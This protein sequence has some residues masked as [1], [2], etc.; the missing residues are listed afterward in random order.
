MLK[1]NF[2][3]G[4]CFCTISSTLSTLCAMVAVSNI[5]SCRM[6]HDFQIFFGVRTKSNRFSGFDSTIASITEDLA[7]MDTGEAAKRAARIEG[8]GFVGEAEV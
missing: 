7:L 3:V 4:N 8:L 1:A 2:S 6:L 5:L